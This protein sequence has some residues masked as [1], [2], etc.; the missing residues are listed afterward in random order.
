M[1]SALKIGQ[2]YCHRKSGGCWCQVIAPGTGGVVIVTTLQTD[3]DRDCEVDCAVQEEDSFN[4]G[5]VLCSF[6]QVAIYMARD[7]SR[8]HSPLAIP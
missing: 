4:G 3:C 7:V 2:F 8:N 1:F 6:K 5:I